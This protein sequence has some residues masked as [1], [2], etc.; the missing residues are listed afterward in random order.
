[1]KRILLTIFSLFLMARVTFA[2]PEPIALPSAK[3]VTVPVG[4]HMLMKL[5]SPLHTTSA[6]KDSAVYLEVIMPVIKDDL[7]VIPVGTH[8]TGTVLQERR[9]GRAKGRARIRIGFTNFIFADKH[10]VPTEG[11][12]Q[13]LPNS[14]HNRRV[15]AEG[16]I[17]AVD[18]IDRDVKGVVGPV[19]PGAILMALGAG[20]PG[21]RLALLGGGLGFGNAMITR[22]NEISLSVGTPVEMVLK[23]DLQLDR[24]WTEQTLPA[25]KPQEP[26]NA[27]NKIQENQLCD[28]EQD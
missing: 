22:G 11:V 4:T 3:T 10:V 27:Q 18:Q 8:V 5:V 24:G 26:T 14:L 7:V 20:I 19:L 9:P 1:M 16:T 28:C 21:M 23:R 12:V 6:T 15:D 17:E 25:V 2:Q 13:G